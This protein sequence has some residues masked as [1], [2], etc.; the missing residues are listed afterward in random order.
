MVFPLLKRCRDWV[1]SL[2]VINTI[3]TPCIGVCSTGLG[4]SV[5]RG[6]K[7]FDHEVIHWNSYS[8]SQKASI[9][10][11]LSKL[12]TQV[13]EQR[14]LIVDE[15][16]LLKQIAHQQIRVFGYR[17]PAAALYELLKAGASQILDT[18]TYGFRRRWF[19]RDHSL[20]Q[21]REDIDQE[22][23]ALSVAHFERFVLANASRAR[24]VTG[25]SV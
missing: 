22:F 8:Q 21:I 13:V 18:G 11:R 16:L 6:C 23:Y 15:S 7:R 12:L 19:Y 2:S 25:D 14:L 17:P 3:K 9:D 24:C 20:A 5:C 4:D 1:F 10:S